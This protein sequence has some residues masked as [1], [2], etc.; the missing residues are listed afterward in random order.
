M[1]WTYALFP[2][3]RSDEIANTTTLVAQH[4]TS[5]GA[6]LAFVAGHPVLT[7]SIARSFHPATVLESLA[8]MLG[9]MAFKGEPCPF[10]DTTTVINE[11]LQRC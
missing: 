3:A 8:A 10:S 1:R 4:T 5:A 2:I 6:Q 9:N 11:D 7:V